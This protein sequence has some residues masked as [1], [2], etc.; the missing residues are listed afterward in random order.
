VESKPNDTSYSALSIHDSASIIS[1]DEVVQDEVEVQHMVSVVPSSYLISEQKMSATTL[2]VEEIFEIST[3]RELA[4][5]RNNDLLSILED[6]G[7]NAFALLDQNLP[8]DSYLVIGTCF[9]NFTEDR[10]LYHSLGFKS[11]AYPCDF[12]FDLTTFGSKKIIRNHPQNLG[13]DLKFKPSPLYG[14]FGSYL[15]PAGSKE[16]S[17]N[18]IHFHGVD[19][20]VDVQDGDLLGILK[21]TDLEGNAF[22]LPHHMLSLDSY[23]VIGTC[24]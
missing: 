12:G 23:L 5:V 4:D 17:K 8:M 13:S 14:S 18:Y 19:A 1:H 9:Q 11:H 10:R 7:G 22:A 15:T 21:K 20:P 6:L 24:F 3:S 2:E 16:I